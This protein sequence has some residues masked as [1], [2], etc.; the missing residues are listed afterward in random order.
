MVFL[1]VERFVNDLAKTSSADFP[2]YFDPG[3]AVAII[4]YFRDLCPFSLQPFQQ[5]IVANLFGWK[6]L[7]DACPIH[8]F[9]HRRFRT[10]YIEIG[11][12]SGKTPLAAG[13]GT[14]GV[15]S[16]DEPGAEVYVAAPGKEQAA[17]CFR[18]AVGM[19]DKNPSLRK[20]FKQHGCSG[21]M[22]S[23]NLSVGTSFM[24]PVSAEHKTLDGPR[25]H[26]VI[27]DELHEHPNTLVLDKLTAGFK[28]RHQP[29]SFEITNSGWDRDTI[30]FYHHD[31]SRQVLEGIVQNEAWFPYVC[32]LDVC[33][34]CRAQGREQPSCDN[35]DN[36]LDEDVWIK[37]NP[38]LGTI[39]QRDY[40]DKQVKE[41]LE[42]PATRNLKQ[43]LNFCIWTQSEERFISPEAWRTCSWEDGDLNTGDPIAWRIAKEEQLKG[44]YCFGGLD[45]G[46]VNDF[47]CHAR[48]YPKQPGVAKAV[49][50]LDAWVPEDV[51]HHALLKER[52]GYHEWVRGG[53]LT[54]TPGNR[55]DYAFVREAIIKRSRTCRISE[56]A[57]DP[58]YSTQL[59]QELLAAGIKMVEHRQGTISMTYPIKEF[60]RQILGRDFVHGMNP[61]LTFMVDNLVVKADAI[62]NLKCMKPENPNSYKKVDG[63]VA[64][65]MAIGRSAA[66]PTLPAPMAWRA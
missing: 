1:T 44:K 34:E 56:L 17:F 5:F 59:V 24:R 53:F 16:D 10:A 20:I 39:L 22:L 14:Y 4:R 45:L 29:L 43:R 63:A 31:Y 23:G 54:V 18:D 32:Q 66:N 50:L 58:A 19:V 7:E 64:S 2:Y 27:A 48:F 8:K 9:G 3:G 42:I 25:P 26:I 46:V 35:C 33:A 6:R 62:G 28:A 60:Q 49:L 30:C 15:C 65:I 61:L 41:A 40:L 36:W 52:Y 13:I 21:K 55:T 47:T 38:G 57:F 51:Q 12:G 11:K 37:T